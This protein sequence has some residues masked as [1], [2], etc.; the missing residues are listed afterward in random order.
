MNIGLRTGVLVGAMALAGSSL[1]TNGYW[2]HGFGP[3]S[4]SMAGACVAMSFGAMCAASNPGSL[5]VVGNRFEMGMAVFS[6]DRGFKADDNAMSPPYASMPAG[7]YE[8]ANDL[9][10]IPHVAY[11]QML[12]EVSSIGF[13]FG[14]NGGMNTEYGSD[15]FRNFNNPMGSATSPAGVD[16]MQAFLGITYS[17]KLNEQHSI[18]ITPIV[19]VQAFEAY[20]LEPFKALSVAP[21]KVTG[22]GHDYAYGGGIKFGWLW[23]VNSQLNIGASYQSRLW[24]TEFDDYK[25]LFAEGGDFDVPS[26]LDLGF[27]YKA[28]PDVTLAFNYQRI[29]YSEVAALGNAADMAFVEPKPYLGCDDCLGFGWDDVNVYKFGVQWVLD[30]EWTVRAGYSYASDTFSGSQALFNIIAPAVVKEHFTF[31]FGKTLSPNSELN[32]AFSYMPENTVYGTN[33]NT[34]PQTGSISMDQWEIEVGWATRF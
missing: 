19:A 7:T 6:P 15:V 28:T 31:G 24:M 27:A 34:G 12:D 8:S 20:G 11:N 30:P 22:N 32:V 14:G 9:F 29:N 18:G 16:M 5:A 3:K 17:R 10:F 4:K 1:A 26:N 2:T 13:A 25:G 33:P 21:D 23:Q